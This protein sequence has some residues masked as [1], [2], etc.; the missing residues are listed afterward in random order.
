MA[1]VTK[2]GS[3]WQ[4]RVTHK[5]L[6]S[7]KY[8]DTFDDEQSARDYASSLETLLD[9]GIVP[10][11]LLEKKAR[12]ADPFL[13]KILTNHIPKAA[14]SDKDILEL[15]VK[16]LGDLKLS[17]VTT[18]WTDKWVHRMKHEANLAPGTLRKRVE[19]LA[20]AIDEHVR[21]STPDGSVRLVNP[22]RLMPKGYSKYRDADTKAL[23]KVGKK[24]KFDLSRD[25]RME[26]DEAVRIEAVL[27]GEKRADKQRAWPVEPAFGLLYQL[28]VDTGLRL[29][30]AYK[31]RVKQYDLARGVLNV[32]GSKRRDDVPKPRVVP[33]ILKL[34][35]RL[36][37]WC[38]EMDADELIFPFW[39]GDDAEE[40]RK[41][42]SNRL[43]A[44]FKTLFKYAKT[45]NFRE[46][47][48]RHEATCRWVTMRS[49]TGGWLF[50]DVEICKIMGWS[51]T[52]MMLRYA[53]LRGEDWSSR[54]T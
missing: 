13:E 33:L 48:L 7:G 30:E 36:S 53:S 12:T 37:E 54:L 17:Q 26:L 35:A 3:K 2:R 14:S 16:E 31:L 51:D 52:K 8:F 1:A 47:D 49:P 29:S 27:D 41:W 6:P 45:P 50:S 42:T 44:K 21:L 15:L 24:S 4:I 39:S 34:R 43:S 10:L 11:E 28:I 32:D 19:S 40:E 25:R 23:E 18:I 9:G 20:R 46:H 5:L 22:L 38:K